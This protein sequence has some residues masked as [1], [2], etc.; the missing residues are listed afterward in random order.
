MK[1]FIWL[2]IIII[3]VAIVWVGWSNDPT[4]DLIRVTAPTSGAKV[5]SP[6]VVTG[7]ARGTWFFEA[8]FPVRLFDANGQE[9]TVGIAQAEGEWMTTEF[10]PFTATLNFGTPSTSQGVLV[11]QKDNPSGLPEHDAEVRLPVTF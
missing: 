10:V 5:S 4:S 6:L 9:L 11:L 1:K 3:V 7:E 2:L 8:S